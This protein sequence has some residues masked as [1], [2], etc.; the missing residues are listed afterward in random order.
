MS[1]PGPGPTDSLVSKL[2]GHKQEARLQDAHGCRHGD[3]VEVLQPDLRHLGRETSFLL[4]LE[5]VGGRGPPQGQR[6]RTISSSVSRVTLKMS[7]CSVW[8]RKKNM[9]LVLWV[10]EQTNII[11]RSG[12]SRSFCRRGGEGETILIS[13]PR[14][15]TLASRARRSP[16]G[17][18]SGSGCL[19]GRQSSCK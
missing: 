19:A 18:G 3:G 1:T 15:L 16:D 8:A 4:L 2:G 17:V 9:D 5:R 12:S 7:P 10:A 6:A 14:R 11:P 13:A